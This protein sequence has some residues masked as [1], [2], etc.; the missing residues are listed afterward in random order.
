MDCCG[1]SDIGKVRT[2]NED[3]FLI[4]DV[5]KSMRVHYTSLALDHQT[6]LF[7]ESQG[8]LLLVA[9][10]MG[11]HE[12]G[13]RASQLVVD[14]LVDYVLNR[15]TWLMHDEASVDQEF[16]SHLKQA[17]A[18]CQSRIEHEANAV[19]QWRGMG[20]TVTLAYLVWP[21]MYLVHVGDSRC[22]LLRDGQL[23]QLTRDHTLAELAAASDASERTSPTSEAVPLDPV[24]TRGYRMEN[25]LW[26]AVEGGVDDLFPDAST[27]DLQLGDGLVLCT[28]GLHKL[29]SP[30]RLREILS[31]DRPADETC[32]SLVEEA[33]HRGGTDNI[34]AVVCRFRDAASDG[35]AV[36]EVE[37]ALE[38]D[39]QLVDTAEFAAKRAEDRGVT[40]QSE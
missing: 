24:S 1:V 11:G 38:T 5:C 8:S 34:T 32:R 40:S 4:A 21:R 15:L 27:M 20:S 28:D 33:N 3:H 18:A 14:S 39:P 9:D 12:A 16:E 2:T 17:L 7:G 10:G 31:Q 6:R 25:F 19:P 35:L 29:V 30:N 22:Y 13:E 36:Q 23:Q 37:L 26:N